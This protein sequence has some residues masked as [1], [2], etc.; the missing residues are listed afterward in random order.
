V[1]LVEDDLR[2]QESVVKLIG[3]GDVEIV[4]RWAKAAQAL[5]AAGDHVFDCMIIDLKL[6]D[7]TGSELLRAWP[8]ARAARSRRSSSTPAAT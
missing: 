6:P 2:Q 5:R 3:D 1:L 4:R 7:M 8:R